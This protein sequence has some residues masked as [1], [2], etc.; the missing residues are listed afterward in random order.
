MKIRFMVIL[1][2][3]ISISS[4]SPLDEN[5]EEPINSKV[6]A[7]NAAMDKMYS[8][9]GDIFIATSEPVKELWQKAGWGIS[10]QSINTETQNIPKNC[11]LYQHEGV[12][13]QW[14][15]LCSGNVF[16]PQEGAEHIVVMIIH[17][18]G[19]KTHIQVAPSTY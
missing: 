3:I 2:I 6:F 8:F 18:D 19:T 1:F 7:A 5:R 4:C 10:H 16:I 13:N 17:P 9:S 15:G 14:I 12:V 11:T